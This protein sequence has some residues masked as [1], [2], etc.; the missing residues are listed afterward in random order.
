M[1][2]LQSHVPRLGELH[3]PPLQRYT[4]SMGHG[5]A[6]KWLFTV[7]ALV[8]VGAGLTLLVAP[9]ALTTLL[10]GTQLD[11]PTA[12]TVGRVAGVALLALVIACWVARHDAH[13]LV[14]KGLVAGMLLYNAGVVSLLVY[15]G[16]ALG[17]TGEGL[18]PAILVHAVL[19]IWCVVGLASKGPNLTSA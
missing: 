1:H 12:L 7:F 19:G 15:A 10:V 6:M 13:S 11:T 18:W 5:H 2:P 14:A 9:S 16:T 8:E 3:T 17:L 4:F